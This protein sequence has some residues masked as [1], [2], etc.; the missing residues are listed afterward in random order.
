ML[1]YT[2]LYYN[3][4]YC[5]IQYNTIQYNTILYYTILYYTILYYTVLYCTVLYRIMPCNTMMY[6]LPGF[7]E[8]PR[9]KD[10]PGKPEKPKARLEFVLQK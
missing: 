8:Q 1:Y 5:V 4:L 7:V 2:L 10:D 6:F 9:Y 3:I